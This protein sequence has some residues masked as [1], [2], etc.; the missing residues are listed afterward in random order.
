M[1]L[2]QIAIALAS[3]TALTRVRWLFVLAGLAAIG[4]AGLWITALLI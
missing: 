2:L 4:T 1:T 3:V